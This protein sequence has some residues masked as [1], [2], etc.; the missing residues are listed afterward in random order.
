MTTT[1][2]FMLTATGLNIQLGAAVTSIASSS[3]AYAAVVAIIKAGGTEADVRA[4]LEEE[5]AAQPVAALAE[6]ER[7]EDDASESRLIDVEIGYQN[8]Y[9]GYAGQNKD[10]EF[11]VFGD[12]DFLAAFESY[13]TALD[14]AKGAYHRYD[15]VTVEGGEGQLLATLNERGIVEHALQGVGQ[16]SDAQEPDDEDN[17][18]ED[19][20][21][22]VYGDGGFVQDFPTEDAAVDFV[23]EEIRRYR[24]FEVRQGDEVVRTIRGLLD[25]Y[26]VIVDGKAHDGFYSLAVAKGEAIGLFA[27]DTYSSVKVLGLQGE[28]LLDL[29]D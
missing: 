3:P 19:T 25:L 8:V 10:G 14:Y 20:T 15:E 12:E 24:A 2:N 26:M 29:A 11:D 21:F 27:T 28:V 7:F 4:A 9:G 13:E 6:V 16:N 18:D 5:P 22:A 1:L 17:G 23:G